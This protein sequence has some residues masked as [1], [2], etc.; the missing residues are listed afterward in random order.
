MIGEL[1]DQ[2]KEIALIGDAMN[3]A[4][5]ILE[6]ARESGASVL[7]SAPYYDAM[8]G[9]PTRISARRLAPIALRG[10]S[11]PLALVALDAD[12]LPAATGPI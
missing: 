1:G 8:R 6:A 7:I 11:A 3:T 4:A 9:A 12:G 2:K 5:R 10:K